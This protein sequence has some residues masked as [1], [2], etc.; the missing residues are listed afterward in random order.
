MLRATQLLNGPAGSLTC[1]SLPLCSYPS[2]ASAALL[3]PQPFLVGPNHSGLVWPRP[4][5]H[6]PSAHPDGPFQLL[7]DSPP[8]SSECGRSGSDLSSWLFTGFPNLRAR[9]GAPHGLSHPLHMEDLPNQQPALTSLPS[10]GLQC[11]LGSSASVLPHPTLSTAPNPLTPPSRPPG[12]SSGLKPP[13][14]APCHF[15][16]LSPCSG[17]FCGEGLLASPPQPRPT[18]QFHLS[19]RPLSS[20]TTRARSCSCNLTPRDL[21]PSSSK[22]PDQSQMKLPTMAS[23]PSLS[24][25]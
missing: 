9:L 11:L 10:P 25:G 14:S 3:T 1:S 8:P 6:S 2:T 24:G 15:P 13:A 16:Q 22:L 19:T 4:R 21:P 23:R 12:H 7:R 18:L 17:L 5:S 20:A